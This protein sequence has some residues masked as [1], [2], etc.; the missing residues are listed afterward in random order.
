MRYKSLNF[1]TGRLPLFNPIISDKF[2][3]DSTK[4]S[5][6][7]G[8]INGI[9]AEINERI[10]YH[11]KNFKDLIVVFSGG[12]ALRLSKPFKNEIFADTNFL[13]KGLNSI[14]VSNLS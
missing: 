11:K 14:L 13:A 9:I 2:I 6:H 10:C 12:D 7:A 4:S 3:G 5:I 1:F 8:V